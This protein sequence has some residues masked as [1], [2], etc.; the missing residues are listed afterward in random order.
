MDLI[1][2]LETMQQV[3]PEAS[4]EI[5]FAGSMIEFGW[6]YTNSNDELAYESLQC[7]KKQLTEERLAG[8]CAKARADILREKGGD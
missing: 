6:I 3:H 5:G 7:Q 1:K 4:P 2:T 8:I